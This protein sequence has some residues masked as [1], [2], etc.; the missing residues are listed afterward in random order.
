MSYT[1]Q[2]RT[3]R[4]NYTVSEINYRLEEKFKKLNGRIYLV[5][6]NDSFIK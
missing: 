6:N 5:I 1:K 3:S 2:I 4:Q